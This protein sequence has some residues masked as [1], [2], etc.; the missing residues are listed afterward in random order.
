MFSNRFYSVKVVGAVILI[1]CSFIYSAYKGFWINP[2][3]QVCMLRPDLFEGRHIWVPVA[4]VKEVGKGCFYIDIYGK[5]F[6]V[7]GKAKRIEK[8]DAI[9]LTGWF[10]KGNYIELN[11][12][13]KTKSVFAYDRWVMNLCSICVLI[14]VGFLLLKNFKAGRNG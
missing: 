8:G 9:M 10:R 14:L 11:R 2:A 4:S 7:K 1:L 6:L 3:P 13:V 5:Q 12:V